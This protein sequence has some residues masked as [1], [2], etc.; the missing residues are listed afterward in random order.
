MIYDPIEHESFHF[1]WERNDTER[2]I[3]VD[4]NI[5]PNPFP[6]LELMNLIVLNRLKIFHNIFLLVVKYHVCVLCIVLEIPHPP[7]VRPSSRA[8]HVML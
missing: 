2:S 8:L 3:N 6:R 5:L 1:V 7:Y 4:I